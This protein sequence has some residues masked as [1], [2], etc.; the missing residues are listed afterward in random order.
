MSVGRVKY[1]RNGDIRLAYRV[2][3]DGEVPVVLVPG[4]VSNVDLYDDPMT[5][6]AG[7]AER[8]SRH[9]RLI[10]W[11][12]RGT[13]LSD[14]VSHVPPIDERM[15]DLRAVLDAA[16]V[17][18][19]ALV[20]VSEGGPMSLVFAATYPERVRSLMLVGTTARFAQDL[21]DR[22]WGFTP[23]QMDA[24]LEDI[25]NHWGEG[26][27]AE[28]F[29]GP[30]A[31]VPGVRDMFGKEQRACASPMMAKLMWQAVRDIDVRGVLESVRTPTMVLARRGDRI[32]RFE[33]AQELA[34]KIPNAELRELPPGEHYA[35]DLLEMLPQATLEFVGQQADATPAERVLSTVLFTDI[36]GS[37]EMLAAHGDDQW[38]RQLDDHD[39]LVDMVL[40]RYGGRRAKHTGDG[41]FALFD[42]PTKAARCGLDL[43]PALATH[44]IP[45]RAGVHIGECEKRGDEWSGMA[46]HVGARIGAIAG[47]GE[48]LTSRT[49][50]DLSVGSG[51]VFEGLGPRR[52][53]GLPEDTEVFR[54]KAA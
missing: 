51:L 27:M 14:P 26:A 41:I 24:V 50:R 32:A 35:T 1:A 43:V 34:A 16:D 22:P 54:V 44:G 37:T 21:P 28:W 31:E 47:A 4:W 42:G 45:I 40:A 49:V 23:E 52:L 46:V 38:R 10:V 3:G 17:E 6:Y 13:G 48:V 8:L 53:K 19:P 33:A 2:M 36:V 30:L 12:K 11:D 7:I 20:G 15:D 29:F 25:E 39:R 18:F 5:L 9:V